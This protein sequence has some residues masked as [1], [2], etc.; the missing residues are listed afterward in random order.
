VSRRQ[1]HKKTPQ[2]LSTSQ[3]KDSSTKMVA[4][5]RVFEHVSS[6]AVATLPST[7]P[8]SI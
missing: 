8:L 2:R 1:D 5:S 3:Y 4:V 6:P 7:A